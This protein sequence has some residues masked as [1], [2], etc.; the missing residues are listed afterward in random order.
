MDDHHFRAVVSQVEGRLSNDDRKRLQSFLG[1]KFPGQIGEDPLHSNIL[2]QIKSLFDQ[3]TV[4]EEDLTFL[5]NSFEKIQ[6]VDAV[7]L[8]RGNLLF[9]KIEIHVH[10]FLS[11]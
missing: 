2:N 11:F 7:N 9:L 4:N 1:E 6:C 8:L 10:F 5:I 3:D